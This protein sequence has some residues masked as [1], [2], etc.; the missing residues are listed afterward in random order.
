MQMVT[1]KIVSQFCWTF[2]C[3]FYFTKNYLVTTCQSVKQIFCLSKVLSPNECILCL[4]WKLLVFSISGIAAHTV[5]KM[6]GLCTNDI[7]VRKGNYTVWRGHQNDKYGDLP[8]AIRLC[9]LIE[10]IV[11]LMMSPWVVLLLLLIRGLILTVTAE[12]NRDSFFFFFFS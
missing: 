5:N 8:T 11:I 4:S 9:L 10:S 7:V 12:D 6:T 2:S 1:V 3:G